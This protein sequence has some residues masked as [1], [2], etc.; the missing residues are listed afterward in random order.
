MLIALEDSISEA[1]SRSIVSTSAARSSQVQPS[2][3]ASMVE[4][5]LHQTEEVHHVSRPVDRSA[6]C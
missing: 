1:E 5:L 6:R 3:E 4:Y 2:R